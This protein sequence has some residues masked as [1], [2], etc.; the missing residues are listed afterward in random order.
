[1]EKL[2]SVK[3]EAPDGLR[4][5]GGYTV[6]SRRPSSRGGLE[7]SSRDP[8]HAIT[9]GT[10]TMPPTYQAMSHP[11]LAALLV[12]ERPRSL[13][14]GLSMT[15]PEA[16]NQK[17]AVQGVILRSQ[18]IEPTRKTDMAGCKSPGSEPVPPMNC[19]TPQRGF[20]LR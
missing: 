10:I 14:G 19:G 8:E 20:L 12:L 6:C 17:S 16:R 3:G 15:P 11:K 9:L 18:F 1:M 5:G 2:T 7:Q 13:S 4:P